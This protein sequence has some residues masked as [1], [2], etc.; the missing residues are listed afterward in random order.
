MSQGLVK[1]TWFCFA[2]KTVGGVDGGPSHTIGYFQ[3]HLGTFQPP[4][5]HHSWL[6]GPPA[7]IVM[8]QTGILRQTTMFS[9][10]PQQSDFGCLTH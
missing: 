10:S 3:G 8:N 7:S 5:G 6:V 1:N 4:S 9:S 2:T